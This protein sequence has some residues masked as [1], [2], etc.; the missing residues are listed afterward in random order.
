MNR[1]EKR[2]GIVCISVI[3]CSLVIPFLLVK[4]QDSRVLAG[5]YPF[6]KR[7]PSEKQEDMPALIQQIQKRYAIEKYNVDCGDTY[8]DAGHMGEFPFVP[9]RELV[10]KKIIRETFL[11]KLQKQEAVIIRQWDY[12]AK[13]VAYSNLKIFLAEDDF[14]MAVGSG[15]WEPETE[16]FLKIKIRT[17]Y[18]ADYLSEEELLYQYVKYLQLDMLGDWE[19]EK[20]KLASQKGGVMV[21]I[22]QE[23]E[24]ISIGIVS[25]NLL[26]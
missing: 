12:T 6:Y 9:I 16:K 14:S 26:K 8:F 21:K 3:V 5:S 19:Y 2:N 22:T 1:K 25:N 11:K 7:I 17:E 23:E 18:I 10:N 15:E 4:Q 13:Q 20:G 24:Y